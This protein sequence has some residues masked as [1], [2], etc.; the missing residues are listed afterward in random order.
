MPCYP[1]MECDR[2]NCHFRQ[3]FALLPHYWPRKLKFR[4][5]VKKPC[6]YVLS[7]YTCVY[8][9]NQD[10]MMYGSWDMKCNR[11]NFLSSWAIFCPFTPLTAGKMKYQKWKKRPGDIIILHK[12]TKT[13]DHRL[14]LHCSWDMAGAGCNCCFSLWVIFCLL[15][16]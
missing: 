9:K 10:H 3:F 4:K 1:D 7:F 5:N 16:P 6:I 14:Y 13:H 11:Q 2:K 8:T 12:C 15:S